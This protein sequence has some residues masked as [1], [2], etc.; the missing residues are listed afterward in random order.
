M[1]FPKLP[2]GGHIARLG[3]FLTERGQI[4]EQPIHLVIA[5]AVLYRNLGNVKTGCSMAILGFGL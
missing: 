5:K 3:L 1:V 4:L 2:Y